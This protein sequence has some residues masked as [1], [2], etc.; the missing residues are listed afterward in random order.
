MTPD[1]DTRDVIV[2]EALNLVIEIT[3]K[4]DGSVGMSDAAVVFGRFG[5]GPAVELVEPELN[6][7]E[8]AWL[9]ELLVDRAGDWGLELHEGRLQIT[10]K[11]WPPDRIPF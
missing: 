10:S 7:E 9:L 6:L 4:G 5:G 2:A 1:Q 3:G 11:T 8:I